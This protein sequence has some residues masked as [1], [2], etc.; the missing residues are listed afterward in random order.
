MTHGARLLH[1]GPDCGGRL[2]GGRRRA[3]ACANPVARITTE[4]AV[5]NAAGAVVPQSGVNLRI[6]LDLTAEQIQQIE[7]ATAKTARAPSPRSWPPPSPPCP[8]WSTSTPAT[9]RRQEHAGAHRPCQPV[10]LRPAG[11][12]GGSGRD[13]LRRRGPLRPRRRQ[14]PSGRLGI[15][16]TKVAS[17]QHGLDTLNTFVPGVSALGHGQ[18][19]SIQ[20]SAL[21]PLPRPQGQHAG[22]EHGGRGRRAAEPA[23]GRV[24]QQRHVHQRR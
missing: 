22:D 12:F 15:D 8:W 18:W 14:H 9:G 23:Q 13:P 4:R 17:F 21:A 19:V 3:A 7:Q 2:H 1:S 6:S 24:H 10:R 20:S 11:R 16:S 5:S